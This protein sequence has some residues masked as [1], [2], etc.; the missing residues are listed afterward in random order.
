M[1]LGWLKDKA[2]YVGGAEL[3]Q[4][5]FR[6]AAPDGVEIVDCP[7]GAVVSGLDR[8]VVHN[9]VSYSLADIEAVL[10][11]PHVK[12]VNDAWPAGDDGVRKA[13]LEGPLIFTSPLH[14]ERFPWPIAHDNVQIIPPAVLSNYEPQPNGNRAGSVCLGRMAY[15]KGLRLLAEYPEPIDVYSSVP[16]PSSG[17]VRYKGQSTDPARTL[18]HYKRFVF[19][20]TALEPFGRAVVEAWASGLELVVNGNVGSRHYIENDPQALETAADD[21]WQ[22]VLDA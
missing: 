7:P 8:Y 4:A 18:A 5:E 1:R 20:P 14:R 22:A 11:A 10:A 15:G 2:G 3:T 12:Y 17:S 6:A 16:V 13:L 21:F 9:C 19:L